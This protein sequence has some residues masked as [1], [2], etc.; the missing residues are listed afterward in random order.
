MQT[1]NEYVV[2]RQSQP[3]MHEI[4]SLMTEMEIDPWSFLE[5]YYKDDPQ[6][7]TA[8]IESKNAID[9]MQEG[10]WSGVGN[11]AKAVGQ[12]IWGGVKGAASAIGKQATQ[13]GQLA[14]SAMFGPEQR[15]NTALQAMNA[16]VKELQNNQMVQ[17]NLASDPGNYKKLLGDLAGI[18]KQLQQQQES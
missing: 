2:S 3:L 9:K 4:A 1:F 17:Q 5:Q 18:T 15:Y 12:G 16:L 10:F 6:I 7:I 11:A 13:T 14:R 8:L